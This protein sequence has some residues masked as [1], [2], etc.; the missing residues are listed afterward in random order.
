MAA[1]GVIDAL[2]GDGLKDVL[3]QTALPTFNRKEFKIR[4]VIGG[5]QSSVKAAVVTRN[6]FRKSYGGAARG[7]EPVLVKIGED[8]FTVDIGMSHRN[9]C[10]LLITAAKTGTQTYWQSQKG[11]DY[12]PLVVAGTLTTGNDEPMPFEDES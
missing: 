12:G 9:F 10:N 1:S 3:G 2:F 4:R 8:W 11:S 7:G 6:P 5:P